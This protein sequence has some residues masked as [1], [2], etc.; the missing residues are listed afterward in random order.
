MLQLDLPWWP[1]GSVR[2]VV[3]AYFSMRSEAIATE[4]MRDYNVRARWL[5]EVL[6]D[7]TP[8]EAVTF[9]VLERVAREAR[10]VLEDVT[11][12]MRLQFWRSAV[13]YAVLRGEARPEALVELP[14]WLSGEARKMEDYYTLEQ[15]QEFRLAVPPGPYRRLA[16]LSFWTGQ[17]SVDLAT[18]QLA[19]LEPDHD[20]G[21]P[22]TARGRWWRRNNKSLRRRKVVK[23][24]PCWV[25][26]EP[27]LRELAMAWSAE[28]RAP[29]QLIVGRL[30]NVRRTFHAAAARAGLPAIR[31]NVGF[32][33]S[34]ATMLLSR[35]YPY[36]YVRIA[37]GHVGEVSAQQRADGT[38][39]AKTASPTVLTSH[40]AR[41]ST[42]IMRP[43]M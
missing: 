21:A 15:Y 31:P 23:V 7:C 5:C 18:M 34:F 12:R 20:W 29:E 6:G 10:A 43:R 22:I 13:R 38:P 37:L 40:Y 35:D 30:N 9:R 19:H 39:K 25:A 8:A 14:P 41:A 32:R 11:I 42:D 17:H 33:S 3:T 1:P 16:D 24:R 36:E 28:L 26:M 4:T 2:S 27:E